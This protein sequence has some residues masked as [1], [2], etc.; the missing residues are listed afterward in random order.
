MSPTIQDVKEMLAKVFPRNKLTDDQAEDVMIYFVGAFAERDRVPTGSVSSCEEPGHPTYEAKLKAARKAADTLWD[1]IKIDT[2][3]NTAL[4][5]KETYRPFSAE[6]T[7]AIV[8]APKI[9]ATNIIKIDAEE[10]FERDVERFELLT[11]EA[12]TRQKEIKALPSCEPSLF[13]RL[14]ARLY[15][16]MGAL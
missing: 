13:E 5:G 1:A 16:L 8:L 12:S 4:V 10:Q 6:A 9:Q 11:R 2:S 7:R 3:A 15:R 14:K